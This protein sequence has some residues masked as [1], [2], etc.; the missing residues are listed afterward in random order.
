MTVDDR[1]GDVTTSRAMLRFAFPTIVVMV[2]I[3]SYNIVDGMIVSNMIGT[4]ALAGLNIV[5]PAASLFTAFGFMLST[6]GSAYV[7]KKLGEG[8]VEEARRDFTGVAV[9]GVLIAFAAL[10]ILELWLDEI[11]SLMGADEVLHGYASEYLGAL[12]WFAPIIVLQFIFMQFLI[13]AG[14]PGLSLAGSVLSGLTNIVLDVVFINMGMGMAG[15]AIASGIGSIMAFSVAV[16][17]FVLK[18]DSPVRF[19]RPSFAGTMVVK[20]CSNGASEMVTE[21]SGSVTTLLFNLTMM[22]Y[23]G[24]A[25]VSS[26][27]IIMYVQFLAI[28]VILGYS[29]G[30]APLMSYNLG[31]G[32]RDV[33]GTLF[34][35]SLRL[36]GVVS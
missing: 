28:A 5:M 16:A 25:G 11:V 21:L 20:V 33:M 34:R 6:G 30:V 32:R 10:I 12:A 3:S 1:I 14:R 26:I 29:M 2:C 15:A 8:K 23:L 7:A 19:A 9:I 22:A 36:V 17:Y 27:T 35:T 4:D 24:A 13:V 31:A 18:K